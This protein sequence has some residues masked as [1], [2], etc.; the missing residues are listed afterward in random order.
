M[1][2]VEEFTL[3]YP[4]QNLVDNINNNIFNEQKN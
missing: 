2:K 1:D 3:Q 4:F